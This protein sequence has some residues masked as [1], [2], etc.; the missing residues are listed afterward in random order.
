MLEALQHW[1]KIAGKE[2]GAADDQK[3]SAHGKRGSVYI[4]YAALKSMDLLPAL[5]GLSFQLVNLLNLL[6]RQ[7]RRISKMLVSAMRLW[8]RTHIMELFP[9][10]L[11]PK[12]RLATFLIKQWA[13]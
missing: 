11:F 5:T 8:S 9:I 13:Y 2:D 4:L 7:K 3:A 12:L 6:D 10:I 1:K